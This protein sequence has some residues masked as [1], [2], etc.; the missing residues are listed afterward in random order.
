MATPTPPAG[1]FQVGGW[2]NGQQWNGSSF[3]APGVL[4]MGPQAGQAVNPEVIAASNKT[5]GLAAGTNEAYLKRQS[6]NPT[7]TP[8]ASVPTNNTGNAVATTPA[9]NTGTGA[10]LSLGN[11]PTIDL[12]AITQAAYNSPEISASNQKIMDLQSQ[13]TARQTAL[14][15]ASAD[16]NDNPF[17]SEATRVGK[18]AKLNAEAQNDIRTITDQITNEQTT[19]AGRRADAAI[20]VNAAQGQYNIDNTAYQEKLS[21]FNSLV[22]SGALDNAS[23]NDLA[24]LATETGIPVSMIQSIQQASQKKNNPLSIIQSVNDSGQLSILAVDST[25]KVVNTT[26]I[27]GAGTT[28]GSG[29]GTTSQNLG[30]ALKVMTP[31]VVATLNNY[32]NISPQ[33]WQQAKAAWLAQGLPLQEFINNYGS[34]ADTNRGDFLQAYGFPNPRDAATVKSN[35]AINSKPIQ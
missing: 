22:S 29:T 5:Q 27:P 19:L 8:S 24:T 28:K 21:Q 15:K 23:G 1:G 33:D 30:D 35:Q 26:T 32:G 25:G 34:Y 6:A 31:A 12:N 16:I 14:S 11:V 7:Y 17:Y 9:N 4:N 18:Q 3:S 2:Y 13:V 20:K 10:P